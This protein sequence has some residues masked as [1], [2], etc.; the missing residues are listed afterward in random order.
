[1]CSPFSVTMVS[2]NGGPTVSSTAQASDTMAADGAMVSCFAGLAG[3]ADDVGS[4]NIT[5]LG[6]I[7]H[8]SAIDKIILRLSDIPVP[9]IQ[10]VNQVSQYEMEVSTSVVDTQCVAMYV[11][12]TI[13]NDSNGR[14]S[15]TSPVTVDGIDL[16]RYSYSF[17]GY[18]ITPGNITGDVSAPFSFTATLSGM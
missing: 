7:N 1:M 15:P 5:E 18:V 12:N 8:H 16:C 14:S 13:R 6:K 10:S 17:V 3:V 4:I 9:S 2:S 11:V